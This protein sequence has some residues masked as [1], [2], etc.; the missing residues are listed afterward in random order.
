M[1]YFFIII[2]IICYLFLF[3]FIC[4]NDFPF[5]DN[6]IID[7]TMTLLSFVS[8]FQGL[9]VHSVMDFIVP[10]PTLITLEIEFT[11][12]SYIFFLYV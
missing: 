3:L 6:K 12:V 7:T 4:Y 8:L 2:I 5:T 1:S 9:S 11:K 10:W